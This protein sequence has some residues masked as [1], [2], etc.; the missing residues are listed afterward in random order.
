MMEFNLDG[1][2][3]EKYKALYSDK[4][5][6][7]AVVKCLELHNEYFKNQHYDENYAQGEL[8]DHRNK[9]IEACLDQVYSLHRV[10]NEE[11]L[12]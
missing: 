6:M 5:Q 10:F 3:A 8:I 11:F 1:E 7:L 4:L 9:R 12:K 2:S